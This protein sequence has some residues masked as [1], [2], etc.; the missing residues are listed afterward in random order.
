MA[1]A[2]GVAVIAALTPVGA[3]ACP[4][5]LRAG[6]THWP[7]FDMP[8]PDGATGINPDILRAVADRLD[9]QV[10]FH[11]RP[12]GRLLDELR[13]GDLDVTGAA[14]RTADRR[15]Y[16]RFSKR[17]M[18]YTA[19]LF[20]DSAENGGYAGLRAFLA[21]GH[22]LAVIRGYTYGGQT[23]DILARPAYSGQVFRMYSADES[24]R[25]VT[26]DRVAGMLG[27][28]KV[29]RYFARKQDAAEAIRRTDVV[30]QNTPVHFMFSRSSV[31]A[32]FVARFDAALAALKQAGRIDA[33]VREHVQGAGDG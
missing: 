19:A 6:I 15:A 18:P 13:D 30:V 3:G 12:W 25:A 24:V 16:A 14:H 21:R 1:G 10:T 32:D 11:K 5:P 29:V 8:S 9:C 20:V 31:S 17:Y 26:H 2:A 27:N 23:D 28:P 7:P 33:I 22:S 4:A